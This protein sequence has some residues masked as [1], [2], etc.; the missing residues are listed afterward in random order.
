[1]RIPPAHSILF[2]IAGRLA[3]RFSVLKIDHSMLLN[4]G[5]PESGAQGEAPLLPFLKGAKGSEVPLTVFILILAT[6]FQPKNTTGGTLCSKLTEIHL[7]TLLSYQY[8]AST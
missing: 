6:V 2:S 7:I 1:M 8:K 4:P 5:T 3:N